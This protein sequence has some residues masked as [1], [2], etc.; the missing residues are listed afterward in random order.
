MGGLLAT[1]YVLLSHLLLWPILLCGTRSSVRIAGATLLAAATAQQFLTLGVSTEFFGHGLT[2]LMLVRTAHVALTSDAGPLSMPPF[3]AGCMA[4]LFATATVGQVS[5]TLRAEATVKHVVHAGIYALGCLLALFPYVEETAAAAGHAAVARAVRQARFLTEPAAFCSLGLMVRM[6][7]HDPS[8]IGVQAHQWLGA[9]LLCLAATQLASN[10][11][12]VMP[13]VGAAARGLAR[14]LTALAWMV[15]GCWL[16]HVGAFLYLYR[17]DG[18]RHIGGAAYR[19]LHDML[20]A[21][22]PAADE[23]SAM[24]LAAVL[25]LCSLLVAARQCALAARPA[26]AHDAARPSS[27]KARA[28]RDEINGTDSAARR[29]G[30][31]R[32]EAEAAL[33]LGAASSDEERAAIVSRT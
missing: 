11:L 33:H 25:Y 26:S 13:P 12:S 4:L 28:H 32:G 23:A 21:S 3:A 10:A 19:G 27:C 7:K 9:L 1:S 16:L 8:D 17:A 6:H 15:L 5:T 24:Y 2:G 18:P 14:A 20:W 31:I 22:P 30:E 29:Y